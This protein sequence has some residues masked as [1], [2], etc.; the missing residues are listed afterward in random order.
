MHVTDV[1]REYLDTDL[2][3]KLEEKSKKR[4][5]N[6]SEELAATKEALQK[7]TDEMK[8]IREEMDEMRKDQGATAAGAPEDYALGFSV[9]DFMTMNPTRSLQWV[10]STLAPKI[11]QEMA[12]HPDKFKGLEFMAGP[13]TPNVWTCAGFNRGSCNAKWHL[14]ERPAKNNPTHKFK[15][16]RLHCCTLC[17]EAFGILAV[18]STLSC[19]WIKVNTWKSLESK[20][21]LDLSD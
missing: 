6:T 12:K 1:D 8:R 16:L 10:S 14:H 18:H 15:D 11:N 5:M 21:E 17:Y 3:D 7:V 4:K 13:K 19:P 20:S 9:T 2:R